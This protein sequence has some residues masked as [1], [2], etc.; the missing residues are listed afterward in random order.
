MALNVKPL[1]PFDH[2]E[3]THPDMEVDKVEPTSVK[4]NYEP[5]NQ[6]L[7]EK[8]VIETD[9]KKRLDILS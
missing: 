2:P 9:I 3:V 1:Y 4:N 7:D 6:N 8:K 5:S